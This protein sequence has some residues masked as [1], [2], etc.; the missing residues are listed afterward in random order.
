VLIKC[1]PGTSRQWKEAFD[2]Q[3]APLIGEARENGEE[4]TGFEF[5]ENVVAGQPYDFVLIMHAKSFGFFDRPRLY[6]HYRALF[7]RLGQEQAARLLSEMESWESVVT[8]T[9]VRAYGAP[10]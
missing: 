8:V 7:R 2:K 9:L 6:P 10:K 4:I 1:K 5:F 3:I